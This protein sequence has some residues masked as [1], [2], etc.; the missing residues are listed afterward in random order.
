MKRLLRLSL[1]M[2][3]IILL[4]AYG[5][6]NPLLLVGD[7]DWSVGDNYFTLLLVHVHYLLSVKC[8]KG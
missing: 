2:F 6:N 1:L 8:G 4:S 5:T 3:T 7:A